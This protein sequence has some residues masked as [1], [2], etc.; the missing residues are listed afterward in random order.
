MKCPLCKGKMSKGKTSLSYDLKG[1]GVI[2]VKDVPALS[3]SQCGDAFVEIAE[4]REVEKILS[5]AQKDGVTLGFVSY[6]KAA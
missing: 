2:V 3:C 6:Q 4:A 1:G 5:R